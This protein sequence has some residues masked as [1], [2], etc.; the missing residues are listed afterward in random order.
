M[1]SLL[2]L[3]SQKRNN[4]H[5]FD[6][7]TLLTSAGTNVILLDQ[8]TCVLR[9]IPTPVTGG[10]GAIAASADRRQAVTAY[11]TFNVSDTLDSAYATSTW[12]S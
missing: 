10:I 9:F 1:H 4:I 8:R 2:S 12:H 6:D 3:D 5:L 11:S 7:N